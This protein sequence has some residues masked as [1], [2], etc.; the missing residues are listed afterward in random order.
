MSDSSRQRLYNDLG[1]IYY[2]EF[3]TNPQARDS[4]FYYLRKALA[5][6]DSVNSNNNEITNVTLCLLGQLNIDTGNVLLGKKFCMQVVRIYQQHHEKS[7]EAD[8]WRMMAEELWVCHVNDKAIAAYFD[9]SANLYHQINKIRKETQIRLTK[10]DFLSSTGDVRGAEDAFREIISEANAENFVNLP[11][12]YLVL[13]GRERYK[14]NLDKALAYALDAVKYNDRAGGQR[15]THDYY[16]ELAQIFEELGETE[17]SIYWYKKCI[18]ERQKAGIAQ[19]VIYRTTSLLTIQMIKAGRVKEA[20]SLLRQLAKDNPPKELVEKAS[21]SQSLGYC[22]E[23]VGE[24]KKAEAKFIQ[25]IHDYK[26][27]ELSDELLHIACYDL[28]KFY[29][30]TRQFGKAGTYLEQALEYG[31]STSGRARDLQLLLFKADS[32]NG[33]LIAAISRLQEYKRLDD[34]IFNQAKSKQIEELMIRYETE[35]KDQ[36]IRLLEKESRL[37]KGKLLQAN[38]TRNW[39]MGVAILL[40]II[41]GLLVNSSRVKQRTN[42]KLQL[43]QREIEKKNTTLYQLVREKEWLV[44]EIHHRVKNNFHIVQSLLG[45]QSGYLKNEE[46]V[47]ALADSR[48]R[49]EAMSLVH[50]KLYQSES[51][52]KINMVEYIHELVNYLKSSFSLRQS[53]Q[54]RLEID[55]VELD[56]SHSIPLGLI[57]NEAITNAIKYAFPGNSAGVIRILFKQ[58]GYHNVSLN[59]IDDGI[60]LPEDFDIQNPPSM[61]IRLMRGLSDDIDA[62]F[63]M[64]TQTGTAIRIHFS[65]PGQTHLNHTNN[66]ESANLI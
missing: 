19:Y 31:M 52:S 56:V 33:N 12:I 1:E 22:Y 64:Q 46:V 24:N 47:S 4:A 2:K 65:Y 58:D 54:F 40:L 63:S 66:A 21:L 17:K 49:I 11:E 29:I 6:A 3:W 55:P 59:I 50:Q 8:A 44:R 53:I 23:A 14:G 16:G 42:R 25:M 20:F 43:Q 39:I 62:V 15:F 26:E 38:A 41:V 57:L 37:Q 60:G 45:T 32:A 51:M 18:A 36:N 13:A 61:G 7:N 5:L 30:E 27:A 28:G 9:S 35:K 48:H 34:T 10:M